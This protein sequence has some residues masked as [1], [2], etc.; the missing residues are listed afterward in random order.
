MLKR[1]LMLLII[2]AMMLG[3]APHQDAE[4]G[5]TFNF[6]LSCND[7]NG[8]L[9]FTG[10][11]TA[12][13]FEVEVNGAFA[14]AY[15]S[16]AAFQHSMSGPGTWFVEVFHDITTY[17]PSPLGKAANNPD[18]ETAKTVKKGLPSVFSGTITCD[19]SGVAEVVCFPDG[20]MNAN[21]AAPI[22]IYLV[23]DADSVS[24]DIWK[25]LPDTS[26]QPLLYFT[27]GDL[28]GEGLRIVGVSGNVVLYQLESG[29]Y[30]IN[31]WTGLKVYV[32]R[33]T[34]PDGAVTFEG[35]IDLF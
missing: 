35:E 12:G 19:S 29:E 16:T 32:L 24:L 6:N 10:A 30:Q 2:C 34:M 5:I 20:R 21:C 31:V 3:L 8:V 28:E 33:F 14:A 4:A 23:E 26:G 15:P 13:E 18:L 22:A 1:Y 11:F 17:V 25:I 7:A 27:P 9:S